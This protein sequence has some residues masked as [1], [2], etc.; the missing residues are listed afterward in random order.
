MKSLRRFLPIALVFSLALV[1]ASCDS[2]NGDEGEFCDENDD[3]NAAFFC[4]YPENG[5]N[6][7]GTCNERP[8]ACPATIDPVCGCNDVTYDNEC[9]A[10][11]AGTS[12]KS[13]GPCS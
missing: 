3:C 2:D 6:T 7:I 9:L 1:G 13:G 4:D 5:C 11:M 12:R 8:T 10:Q